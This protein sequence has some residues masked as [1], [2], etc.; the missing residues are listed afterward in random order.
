LIFMIF[1]EEELDREEAASPE[2]EATVL[3]E[4]VLLNQSAGAAA[5]SQ[6]PNRHGTGNGQGAGNDESSIS[7][8]PF[9]DTNEVMDMIFPVPAAAGQQQ[10]Q[11]FQNEQPQQQQQDIADGV[12]VQGA[13]ED[14]LLDAG[15]GA[16]GQCQTNIV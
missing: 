14:V 8:R 1:Q 4:S 10:Q 9:N 5:S 15:G 16:D 3:E 6:Q 2:P 12:G 13:E 11:P 7:L